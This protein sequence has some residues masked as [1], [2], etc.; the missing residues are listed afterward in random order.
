MVFPLVAMLC[1][2]AFAWSSGWLYRAVTVAQAV[3]YGLGIAGLALR[4]TRAGRHKLVAIPA[5]FCLVN[6]ASLQAV[7][8]LVRG[9]RIERWAPARQHASTPRVPGQER[10]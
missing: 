9:N 3:I 1:A 10:P 2:S 8:N 4:R 5:F 7:W 6:A